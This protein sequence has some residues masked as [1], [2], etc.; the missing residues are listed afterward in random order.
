MSSL[1][2]KTLF[3]SFAVFAIVAA[4]FVGISVFGDDSEAIDNGTASSPLSSI[5]GHASECSNQIFYVKIGTTVNISMTGWG[6]DCSPPDSSAS[7]LP[8]DNSKIKTDFGLS[9]TD[10]VSLTGTISKTG[11]YRI[12]VYEDGDSES[13]EIR[14][15]SVETSSEPPINFTS[16]AAVD[17]VSGSSIRYQATTNISGTTFTATGTGNA[18]WLTISSSGLLSG[19]AP[20][21]TSKTT[22]TY[23]I[24]ATSPG[25]Q[26]TVQKVTFEV[27]PV[28]KL[29]VTSSNIYET[30]GEPITPIKINSNIACSLSL[31]NNNALTDLGL[32]WTASTGT[33]SGTP[34][35]TG[36][37]VIKVL[38]STTVGPS[39]F[40]SIEISITIREATLNITSE[41]PT[42]IFA[43]GK[44]YTYELTANQAVTW[45]ISGNPSWLALTGSKVAGQVT[46]ITEAGTVSYTV[47]ASTS[48]GQSVNQ[49][50]TINVEPT[51]VFTSVPTASCSVTP[52]YNYQPDGSWII[53]G[54]FGRSIVSSD[55]AVPVI[56]ALRD[57]GPV[58]DPINYT[59]PDAISVISGSKLTYHPATNISGTIFGILAGSASWIDCIDGVVIGTVP[60]VSKV[61]DYQ[62]VLRAFSPRGQQID[63]TI[64]VTAYPALVLNT[65]AYSTNV[66]QGMPMTDITVSSNVAVTWSKSGDLP[67]GITFSDGKFSGIPTESGTFP[68]TV[69]ATSIEGPSQTA[70]KKITINVKGEPDLKITTSYPTSMFLVGQQYSYTVAANVPNCTFALGSDKPEWAIIDG[71]KIMGQIIG[72][73][74][75]QT[76]KFT[77][78]ATSPAGQIVSQEISVVIEPVIAFTTVPTASC[79]V[80]PE[81]LD[82]GSRSSSSNVANILKMPLALACKVIN[83]IPVFDVPACDALGS[84]V[85][86]EGDSGGDSSTA[87]APNITE[88]GTRTFKFVW[89]GEN[90]ERVVWDF[91][92]GKTGEGFQIVHT[93]AKNGTYKYT[94]TGI[95]SLGE[96]SVSGTI[97]V[98]VADDGLSEFVLIGIGILLLIVLILVIR[99]ATKRRNAGFSG[100]RR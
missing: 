63:Q 4:A 7:F 76:V 46:G 21:V 18:S 20:N 92:D 71:T 61:T 49:K 27:Y 51:I 30:V 10:L 1:H 69:Y 11:T 55:A 14:F 28:A 90:A 79:F 59:A 35:K 25:G 8:P 86:V 72:Y 45:S 64:T 26:S 5:V 56:G 54:L 58:E 68:V 77:V 82:S 47:T 50:V 15:V 39:Q 99:R 87:P 43:V 95:N 93:Y 85:A 16:P 29:S 36:S 67:A 81:H 23:S 44:N 38:G 42:G 88:S 98:D 17:S 97:T 74:D 73:T 83:A 94:C 34:T 70:E 9:G 80:L 91:G 89:T 24:K 96:S 41:P 12:Y 22:Y 57:D 75:G 66:N 19:T 100:R 3:A 40:P 78:T 13:H 33:I 6:F 32:T 37:A 48:G 2:S 84:P 65:S 31:Q 52:V 60:N 62:A 53:A